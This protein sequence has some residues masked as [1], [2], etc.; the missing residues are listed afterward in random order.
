MGLFPRVFFCLPFGHDWVVLQEDREV[1]VR[2]CYLC[3]KIQVIKIRESRSPE[4]FAKPR[5][6]E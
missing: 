4:R 2:K 1:I 3:D 5:R 6:Y